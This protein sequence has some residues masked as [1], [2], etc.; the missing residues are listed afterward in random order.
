LRRSGIKSGLYFFDYGTDWALG[1]G[2]FVYRVTVS[3]DGKAEV[4]G[5]SMD[6]FWMH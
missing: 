6:K 3:A 1:G 4:E 2:Y 5:T